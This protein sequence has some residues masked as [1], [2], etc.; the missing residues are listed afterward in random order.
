[1]RG[2]SPITHGAEAIDPGDPAADGGLARQVSHFLREHGETGPIPLFGGV[3]AEAQADG[4]VN[5]YWR[6]PGPPIF[7][8]IRRR[9]HLRRWN[10][11]LRAW[12][13]ATELL[14]DAPEPHVA[15]WGRRRSLPR[16][17]R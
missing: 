5:V 14:L 11:R 8:S 7:R 12:G 10:Q 9:R 16:P 1:M 6:L 2:Q 4:H 13:M 3:V 17:A 15:C